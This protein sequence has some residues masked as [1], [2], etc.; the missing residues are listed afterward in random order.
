MLHTLKLGKAG[1]PTILDDFD[2]RCNSDR[3]S[4]ILLRFDRSSK[5]NGSTQHN[6]VAT[7][8]APGVWLADRTRPSDRK[9]PVKQQ[10]SGEI[11]RTSRPSPAQ[12]APLLT[13]EAIERFA[14][15]PFSTIDK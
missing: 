1:T 13:R 8:V 6:T 14:G 10:L 7:T 4:P 2:G 11:Y 3:D 5:W 15:Y 9:E 12:C